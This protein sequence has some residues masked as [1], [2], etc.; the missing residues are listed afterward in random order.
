MQAH[1][2]PRALTDAVAVLS[3]PAA[4]AGRPGLIRLAQLLALSAAGQTAPQRHR[5]PAR[6]QPVL[7]AIRG[8]KS[9]ALRLIN[10][11]AA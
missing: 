9:P 3:N 4:H 5:D 8:G 6:P 1:P 11:G 2:S 7:R 10:G